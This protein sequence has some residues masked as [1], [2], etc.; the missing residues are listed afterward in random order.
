MCV[1]GDVSERQGGSLLLAEQWHI[2]TRHTDTLNSRSSLYL[3]DFSI[4]LSIVGR[5]IPR[6]GL[7]VPFRNIM[8]NR[9]PK[10]TNFSD[11]CLTVSPHRLPVFGHP[12]E[13]RHVDSAIGFLSV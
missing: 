2:T 4:P 8:N 13:L 11:D 12:E 1:S 9:D 6:F 10:M 7:C 5:K 3:S